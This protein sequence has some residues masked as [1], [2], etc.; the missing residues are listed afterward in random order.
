MTWMRFVLA[1]LAT[2]AVTE[3]LVDAV[4]FEKFR[5][6]LEGPDPQSPRLLGILARCGYCASFWVGMGFACALRPEFGLGWPWWLGL[7]VAGLVVHRLSNL[8]HDVIYWPRKLMDAI[9][10]KASR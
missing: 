9:L 2:E 5:A 4:I 8:W 6:R 7:P 3:I 10:L 1:V